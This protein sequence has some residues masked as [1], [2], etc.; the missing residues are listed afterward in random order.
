M[1]LY[2]DI[3]TQA[4]DRLKFALYDVYI[5]SQS[6]NEMGENL[7]YSQPQ[8]AEQNSSE[9]SSDASLHRSFQG[10]GREL[11][12]QTYFGVDFII[13]QHFL[14]IVF[15]HLFQLV[16]NKS[17]TNYFFLSKYVFII[18]SLLL[19]SSIMEGSKILSIHLPACLCR[20][21]SKIFFPMTHPHQVSKN[22]NLKDSLRLDK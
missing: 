18:I 11:H 4:K 3:Q 8:L 6:R 22:D 15:T 16:G 9:K 7:K 10:F 20:F 2:V 14:N 19:N 1:H 21:S 5:C 13:Q 17:G 12:G